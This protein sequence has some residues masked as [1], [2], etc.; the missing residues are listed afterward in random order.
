MKVSEITNEELTRLADRC[1][2]S[3]EHIAILARAELD[4]RRQAKESE[5]AKPEASAYTG[6]INCDNCC[7]PKLSANKAVCHEEDCDGFSHFVPSK[8]KPTAKQTHPATNQPH[9]AAKGEK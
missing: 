5:A 6:P 9:N 4:D 3:Y 1:W 7:S 8:P 2:L